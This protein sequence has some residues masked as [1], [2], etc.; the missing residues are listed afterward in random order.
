MISKVERY[1]GVLSVSPGDDFLLL[2]SHFDLGENARLL[3]DVLPP[4]VTVEDESQTRW[5]VE[6]ILREMRNPQPGGTLVAQQVAYTLLIDA[7]RLH[8]ADDTQQSSGW[9]C[10]LAD[11]RMR[12]AL[13]SIHQTPAQAWTLEQLARLVGMSRTAFAQTFKR[14][15]GETPMA[16]LVC[17][18]GDL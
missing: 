12:K 3:L 6:R 2:G 15:V 14:T 4:I 16:Y 7:L 10:A 5:A 17:C 11:E 8:L 13:S 18:P 1:N 9:L